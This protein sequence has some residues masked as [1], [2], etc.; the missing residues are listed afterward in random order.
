MAGAGRR[1]R[2]VISP[3]LPPCPPSYEEGAKKVCGFAAIFIIRAAGAGARIPPTPLSRKGGQKGCAALRRNFY[4]N[5]AQSAATLFPRPLFRKKGWP[6]R[7]GVF[8]P[9][10]S[11]S[12]KPLYL[13]PPQAAGLRRRLGSSSPHRATARRGPLKP[14]PQGGC[15]RRRVSEANRRAAAALRPEMEGGARRRRMRWEGGFIV[16]AQNPPPSHL[17]PAPPRPAGRALS[18]RRV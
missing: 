16:T 1:C 4:I 5:A 3:S 12:R 13:A 11:S 14:S 18:R 10:S 6:R 15:A 8:E 9:S 2:S 17:T 7:A